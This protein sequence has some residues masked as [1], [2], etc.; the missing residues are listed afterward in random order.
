MRYDVPPVPDSL[1]EELAFGLGESGALL[2][3]AQAVA[4]AGDLIERWEL[5]PHE[6]LSGGSMSLC[7]KCGG[8]GGAELVLKVPASVPGGVTEKA[9]LRAW[10]GNG[11][12]RLLAEDERTSAMLMNFLGRVGEGSYG[13]DDIVD[14]AARLHV[15]DPSGHPFGPIQENLV[16]RI[17]W[18]RDRFTG[19]GDEKHLADLAV[20]EELLDDLVSSQ[21]PQVLLHGDLQ[22]KNLIV[23]GDV[24]TAVDPLPTLGPDV[25]DLAFWIA[26]NVHA[27]P[28]VS[29]VDQVAETQP[30]IDRQSL[31]R[32]A[33]A[34]AVL[35]NRPYLAR[36]REQR[37]EFIDGLRGQVIASARARR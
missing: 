1:L 23:H 7:I 16:R 35:E 2:W 30:D 8:A 21:G 26:K 37:Q 27:G 31:L 9:A 18:A 34:L 13:L 20:T 12:A 29:Y 11:A 10:G 14:L 32:W 36:G 19:T 17:D 24:L 3:L 4:T 33:W 15:A 5:V 6:V 25:F 22:A 28:T